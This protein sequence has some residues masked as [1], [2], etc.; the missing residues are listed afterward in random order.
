MSSMALGKIRCIRRPQLCQLAFLIAALLLPSGTSGALDWPADAQA[1]SVTS[2]PWPQINSPGGHV[3]IGPGGGPGDWRVTLSGPSAQR[4]SFDVRSSTSL[5]PSEIH[6]FATSRAVALCFDSSLVVADVVIIDL[7]QHAVADA[8][9]AVLPSV[10]P[11]GR[12]VAYGRRVPHG[13]TSAWLPLVVVYD[14]AST[15]ARNRTAFA[16]LPSQD[17]GMPVFPDEARLAGQY[18]IRNTLIAPRVASS[19]LK[20]IDPRSF[21]FAY[22]AG[23][24]L[25]L[26]VTTLTDLGA[27]DVREAPIDFRRMLRRPTEQADDVI[28]VDDV[29]KRP[30]HGKGTYLVRLAPINVLRAKWLEVIVN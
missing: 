8:F 3:S 21:A 27:P 5:P 11:D 23:G 26:V 7:D 25:G 9:S 14:V 15:A 4:Q 18:E 29:R 16:K 12:Y 13:E 2:R 19:V 20:W 24:Q 30:N 1:R 17:A 22:F 28:A 10:S 6:L